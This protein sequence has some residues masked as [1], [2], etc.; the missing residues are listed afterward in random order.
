MERNG[1]PVKNGGWIGF[2]LFI[3]FLSAGAW[4]GAPFITDDPEI[5]EYKHLEIYLAA[6]YSRDEDG[7][8][9]AAP[10]FDINYGFLPGLQ[11]N[12]VL[13]FAFDSPTGL[14]TA[15]GFGDAELALK[16]NLLKDDSG[17]PETSFYPRVVVPTGDPLRDLGGGEFRVFLPLWIEAKW[18]SWKSYGGGGYWINPGIGNMNWVFLGWEIQNDFSTLFTAGMEVFF[19]SPSKIGEGNHIGWNAGGGFNLD[20]VNHILFSVGQ[21]YV[22]GD[23]ANVGY[24]SRSQG[25]SELNAYLAWQ[26]T[27]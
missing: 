9:G 14:D 18:D 13:P 1:T 25:E 27:L 10:Q 3:W 11:L 20:K 23:D 24:F 5:V 22:L 17:F 4:A 6:A 19:H 7:Q 2:A 21:D 15:Y 16:V 12:L 8:S 26:W